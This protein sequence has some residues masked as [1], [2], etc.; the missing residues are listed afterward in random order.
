[1]TI[2]SGGS[3]S[4]VT[5]ADNTMIATGGAQGTAMSYLIHGGTGSQYLTP[6]SNSSASNNYIAD[7]AGRGGVLWWQC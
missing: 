2:S 6:G 5:L 4:N 1:M 7:P 3:I